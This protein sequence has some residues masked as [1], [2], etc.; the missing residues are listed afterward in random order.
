MPAEGRRSSTKRSIESSD[1][2]EG[3]VR[4]DEACSLIL[5]VSFMPLS[6]QCLQQHG[7]GRSE[8]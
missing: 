7:D 4:D 8:P 6:D 3:V 5:M 1:I 2:N